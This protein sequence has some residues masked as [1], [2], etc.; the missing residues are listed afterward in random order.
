[1]SDKVA[2]DEDRYDVSKS[3][4]R[5]EGLQKGAKTRVK[6]SDANPIS[7]VCARSHPLSSAGKPGYWAKHQECVMKPHG[8]TVS[9]HL[10][11]QIQ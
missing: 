1:M 7:Q 3:D 10:W 8:A 9:S 4:T 5:S 2:L 6:E 11:R